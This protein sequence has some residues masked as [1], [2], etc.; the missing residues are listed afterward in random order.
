[1]ASILSIYTLDLESTATKN[2]HCSAFGG[3][4]MEQVLSN[5]F[6]KDQVVNISGFGAIWSPLQQLMLLW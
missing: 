1:M 5:F 2:N 4:T 3:H 6:W